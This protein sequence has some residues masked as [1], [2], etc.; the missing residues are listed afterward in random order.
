MSK[1]ADKQTRCAEHGVWTS[2]PTP[3]PAGQQSGGSYEVL[4]FLNNPRATDSTAHDVEHGYGGRFVIFGHGGCYAD[5][6]H[7]DVRTYLAGT[8]SDLPAATG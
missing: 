3:P 7:C 1:H 4:V 2:V 5:V 8:E 6:G